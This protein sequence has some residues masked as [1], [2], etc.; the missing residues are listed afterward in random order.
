MHLYL[1]R[2]KASSLILLE[3]GCHVKKLSFWIPIDYV[4]TAPVNTRYSICPSWS[5]AYV[6]K[7]ILQIP[8]STFL[9]VKYT[10]H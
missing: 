4:E 2:T 9:P 6:I 3:S 1:Q 10:S 5:T 7:V 8:A